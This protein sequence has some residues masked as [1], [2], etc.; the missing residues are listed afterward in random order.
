[1]ILLILVLFS[2]YW[3]H[4]KNFAKFS[5]TMERFDVKFYPQI[6]NYPNLESFYYIVHRID[7]ITLFLVTAT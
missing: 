3:V 6:T 1:M 2:L 5:R 7:K 4:L